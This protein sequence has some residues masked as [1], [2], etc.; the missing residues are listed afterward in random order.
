MA[1]AFEYRNKNFIVILLN[2]KSTNR[3]FSE[4][5]TL[6]KCLVKELADTA[7]LK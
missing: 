1:S 4:T 6:L 2:T 7:L 3:R 5:R